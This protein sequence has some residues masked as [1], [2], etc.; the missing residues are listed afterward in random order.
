[1]SRVL[2]ATFQRFSH[3]I[4]GA[5]V[6]NKSLKTISQLVKSSW[7]EVGS[8][9]PENCKWQSVGPALLREPERTLTCA[10][11][12]ALIGSLLQHSQQ[13]LLSQ[14]LSHIKKP[15]NSCYRDTNWGLESGSHNQCATAEAPDPLLLPFF[16]GQSQGPCFLISLATRDSL[17]TSLVP[18]CSPPLSTARAHQQRQ[19]GLAPHWASLSMCPVGKLHSLLTLQIWH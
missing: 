10:P 11:E 17:S 14:A 5:K 18:P 15:W 19:P 12:G 1:M 2:V 8:S 6:A 13:P 4:V 3:W 7:V 9:N 16:S